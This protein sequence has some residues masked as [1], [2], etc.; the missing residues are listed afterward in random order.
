MTF[1]GN[2]LVVN[3]SGGGG[4]VIETPEF[5]SIGSKQ[6]IVGTSIL[7]NDEGVVWTA[8][9]KIW[10]AVDAITTITEVSDSAEYRNRLSIHKD[11]GR[12]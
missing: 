8:G 10:V 2:L 9:S 6:F 4:A 11:K 12:P 1:E 7:N 3:T 5:R